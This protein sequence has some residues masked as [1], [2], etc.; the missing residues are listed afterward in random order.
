MGRGRKELV[1][2]KPVRSGGARGMG[3]WQ[4]SQ[5]PPGSEGGREGCSCP[6]TSRSPG[7]GKLRESSD[8]KP[9]MKRSISLIVLSVLPC[10]AGGGVGCFLFPFSEPHLLCHCCAL[11]GQRHRRAAPLPGDD[12]PQKRTPTQPDS[13]GCEKKQSS[14]GQVSGRQ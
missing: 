1:H 14:N 8:T 5:A 7:C 4:G 9:S 10:R 11:P 3:E 12:F 6:H 2:H 13:K